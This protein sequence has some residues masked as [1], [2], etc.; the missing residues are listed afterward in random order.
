MEME[1]STNWSEYK[2]YLFGKLAFLP[3]TVENKGLSFWQ[4]R[5][6]FQYDN[7]NNFENNLYDYEK[8]GFFKVHNIPGEFMVPKLYVLTEINKEMFRKIL[9]TY[10]KTVSLESEDLEALWDISARQH[11]KNDSNYD[12]VVKWQDI[13]GFRPRLEYKEPFWELIFTLAV[14]KQI[15]LD[16][17]DYAKVAPIYTEEDETVEK[18]PDL[19]LRQLERPVVKFTIIDK[20]LQQQINKRSNAI[21]YKVSIILT[22]TGKLRLLLDGK[23]YTLW[24]YKSEKNNT[25]RVARALYEAKSCPLTLDKLNLKANCNTGLKKLIKNI[26]IT[27]I[28][29]ELFIKYGNDQNNRTTVC[30]NRQAQADIDQHERLL[31]YVKTL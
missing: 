18:I 22:P 10:L 16:T 2:L 11:K 1:I 20:K 9:D 8:D 14:R 3:N 19:L 30:L 24:E 31:E 28:L 23:R 21:K 27:D 4:M 25:L 26:H 12:V 5:Q 29:E 6:F 17:V 15:Q 7:L 13:Y